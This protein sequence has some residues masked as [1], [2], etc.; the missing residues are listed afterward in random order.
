MYCY[1]LEG[2]LD[3]DALELVSKD[4]K[5]VSKKWKEDNVFFDI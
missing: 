4:P 5:K 1:F 2:G 3:D